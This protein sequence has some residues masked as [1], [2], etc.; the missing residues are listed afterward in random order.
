MKNLNRK[1]KEIGENQKNEE[2]FSTSEL[3]F[4]DL[5][6]E[7]IV[8]ASIR[9]HNEGKKAGKNHVRTDQAKDEQPNEYEELKNGELLKSITVLN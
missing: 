3:K 7:I 8:N 9:E 5:I 2:G 4:L 6:S 1:S